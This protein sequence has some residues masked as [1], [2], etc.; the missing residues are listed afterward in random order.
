MRILAAILGVVMLASPVVGHELLI[1]TVIVNSEGAA[2]GHSHRCTEG[3]RFRLVWMKDTTENA[4][5]VIELEK[6]GAKVR[7][8]VLQFACELDDNG[9]RIDENCMTRYDFVFN[10][11]T[12]A[13]EWNFTFM[14]YV[15]DSLN[16]TSTGSVYIQ[17]DIHLEED[18]DEVAESKEISKEA[19]A[20]VI[21]AVSLVAI[22]FLISKIESE[23]IQE[24]E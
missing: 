2:S 18:L 4:T 9:T 6:D 13:G 8:P 10:Q 20:G 12:S 17:E 22:A 11:H 16:K 23:T 1:Y 3:R 21:A 24:K 5:L 14:T 15:N 19:I 7:S